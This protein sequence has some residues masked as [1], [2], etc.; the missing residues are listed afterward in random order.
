MQRVFRPILRR[1]VGNV[2][3]S[4]NDSAKNVLPCKQAPLSEMGSRSTHPYLH[5]ARGQ[6]EMA[7]SKRLYLLLLVLLVFCLSGNGV[8]A[9]G[10]GNIPRYAID[11]SGCPVQSWLTN[12]TVMA[13]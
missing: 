6:V 3:P 8:H 5:I 13:T 10:A 2:Y 11:R 7:T 4:D 12:R 9:F 1:A